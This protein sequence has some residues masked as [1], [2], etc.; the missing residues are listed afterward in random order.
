MTSKAH[1]C[2]CC[3][4][5]LDHEI[6]LFL[7]EGDVQLFQTHQWTKSSIVHISI[8]QLH[9]GLN[10]GNMLAFAWVINGDSWDLVE[11]YAFWP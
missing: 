3:N 1:V 2:L 7:T 11:R 6:C 4:V 9:L 8:D 10:E 5:L